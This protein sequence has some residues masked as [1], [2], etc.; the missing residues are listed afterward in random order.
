MAVE[1]VPDLYRGVDVAVDIAEELFNAARYLLGQATGPG[2]AAAFYEIIPDL[3]GPL[4]QTALPR[5][6]PDQR[7]SHGTLQPRRARRT[8]ARR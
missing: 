8:G 4:Q 1:E 2:V 3:R 6:L 5:S 7:R